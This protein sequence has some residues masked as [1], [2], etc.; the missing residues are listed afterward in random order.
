ME[1]RITSGARKHGFGKR[2]TLLALSNYNQCNT[3]AEKSPDPKI[4]FVGQDSKGVELEIDAVV[5]PRTLLIIHAMPT[6]YRRN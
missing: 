2:R 1:I 4:M 5:L 3:S 6:A